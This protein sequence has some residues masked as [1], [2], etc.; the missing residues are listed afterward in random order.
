M[1]SSLGGDQHTDALAYEHL[2]ALNPATAYNQTD[3]IIAVQMKKE[4][5]M[6][7]DFVA[8][9]RSGRPEQFGQLYDAYSPALFGIIKKI[10]ADPDQAQDVLQDSFVKIWE[11]RDSYDGSR[12]SIFTWMLNISRNTAIDF[13]RS[14]HFR[15]AGNIRNIDDN[16]GILNRST[17]ARTATNT[18][19]IGVE[20]LVNG[21]SPDQ[22]QIIDLMYFNG[23][24]QDEI[25]REFN[26][27]LGT[28]KTRARSAIGKLREVFK[29]SST[30]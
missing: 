24:S 2:P 21:L 16:V 12:G 4:V 10:V 22:R 9:L 30:T 11:K 29:L 18:D 6:E 14:K 15:A 1:S 3:A 17:G 7:S 27:P 8:M 26:I 25:A 28:V 5:F 13:T 20:E 23:L 19:T